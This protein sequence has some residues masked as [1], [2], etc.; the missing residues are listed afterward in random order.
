M[1]T[2]ALRLLTLLI[3][4]AALPAQTDPDWTGRKV[5]VLVD[6][7]GDDSGV[8]VPSSPE[9][10]AAKVKKYGV[11]VRQGTIATVTAV[12]GKPGRLELHLNGGGFTNRELWMIPGIDSIH[13]GRSKEE[14][15]IKSDLI[16]VRDKDRRRRLESQYDSIRLRRVRPLR[17]AY[18]KEQR[19]ARGS[20]LYVRGG[21]ADLAAVL[22]RY[23]T[24]LP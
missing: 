16:G 5:K 12:K 3:L 20:R 4:A 8:E 17:E 13:W 21:E 15:R 11:G 19:A 7:P 23:L 18:E 9:N 10:L 6:L 24:L 2:S 22:G 1:A 14:D